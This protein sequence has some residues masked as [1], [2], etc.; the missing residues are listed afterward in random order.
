MNITMAI[1]NNDKKHIPPTNCI[2]FRQ[3]NNARVTKP[4]L[5]LKGQPRQIRAEMA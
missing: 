1:N 3:V 4:F 5:Y 2:P